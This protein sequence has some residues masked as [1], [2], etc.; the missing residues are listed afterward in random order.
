[1]IPG[2]QQN[3][4]LMMRWQAI[5]DPLNYQSKRAHWNILGA[6]DQSGHHPSH[7]SSNYL[8]KPPVM[9]SWLAISRHHAEH[10]ISPLMLISFLLAQ[11]LRLG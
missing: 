10:S 2:W 5:V 6:V 7:I 8:L 3:P 9:K 4:W 1:M 11:D